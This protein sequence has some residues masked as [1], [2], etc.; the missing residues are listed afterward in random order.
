M[1][2]SVFT[3]IKLIVLL[4]QAKVLEDNESIQGILLELSRRGK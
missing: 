1:D 2:W 3:D 4:K